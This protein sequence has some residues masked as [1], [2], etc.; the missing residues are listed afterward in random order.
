MIDLLS[1]VAFSGLALVLATE[2]FCRTTKGNARTTRP[3]LLVLYTVGAFLALA[4]AALPWVGVKIH[5]L[6]VLLMGWVASTNVAF[7]L[8]GW[9]ATSRTEVMR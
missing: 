3:V 6:H 8:A 1:S 7:R 5:P 9:P 2:C 4:S